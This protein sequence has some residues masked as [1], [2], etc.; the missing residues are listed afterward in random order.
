MLHS[1]VLQDWYIY[2]D[3][4]RKIVETRSRNYRGI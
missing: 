1:N 4:K 2:K 3:A